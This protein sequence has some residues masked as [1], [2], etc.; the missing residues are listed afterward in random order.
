MSISSSLR[1]RR[2]SSTARKSETAGGL[3]SNTVLRAFHLCSPS[4]AHAENR[5]VRSQSLLI[6]LAPEQIIPP[7]HQP[8]EEQQAVEMV[9]LVLHRTSF[10]TLEMEL[11]V[12]AAFIACFERDALGA[13]DVAGEIRHRQAALAADD[14]TLPGTDLGV[15]EHHA[16][17]VG[18]QILFAGAIDDHDALRAAHLR[19]RDA[20][21]AGAGA[22]GLLQ[23]DDEGAQL[24]VEDRDGL[25]LPGEARVRIGENLHYR[26]VQP[27]KVSM[28]VS[29]ASMPSWATPCSAARRASIPARACPSICMTKM[30]LAAV[31]PTS[32]SRLR[33]CSPASGNA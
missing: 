4:G 3:A 7:A 27:T 2:H 8:V 28:G 24:V 19:C 18:R 15:D 20:H 21:R 12:L 5:G 17:V 29:V 26:H 16:A 32:D 10:I 14:Q 6:C 9:D 30:G 25:R 23:S 33:M 13:D 1:M 11:P 22:H 31:P